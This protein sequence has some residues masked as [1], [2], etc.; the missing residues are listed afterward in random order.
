[1]FHPVT[2]V[3]SFSSGFRASF[4]ETFCITSTT[5]G[6]WSQVG[7]CLFGGKLPKVRIDKALHSD[8]YSRAS[9][10]LVVNV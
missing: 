2:S 3:L 4:N 9:K 8:D 7:D 5:W 1:M 10:A 6:K